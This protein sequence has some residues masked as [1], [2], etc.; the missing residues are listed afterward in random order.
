MF[1]GCRRHFK[2]AANYA[3][4]FHVHDVGKKDFQFP[5]LPCSWSNSILYHHVPS[6][7]GH[8]L[9]GISVLL[10]MQNTYNKN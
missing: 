8:T 1:S 7:Q 5:T 3:R 9:K 10:K 4:P 2:D 6:T